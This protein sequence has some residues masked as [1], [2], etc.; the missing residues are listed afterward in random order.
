[1]FEHLIEGIQTT[2]TLANI[3]S[4][5]FGTL[6][7]I[8]VGILP[9][10]GPMVGMVVFLPFTFA[11]E[12]HL[13]LSLLLGVFCGGYFGGAVPAILMG[14]PGVPSSL[15]TSF[16]GFPLTQKGESQTALSAA[17]LGSFGGGI[18]SVLILIFL[19]PILAHVAA[20]FGP[21]EYFSVSCPCRTVYTLCL[22]VW[23]C[24]A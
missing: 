8:I 1:M 22:C 11:M 4:L 20:S 6:V 18:L 13:A 5:V 3:A 14:T 24:S 15:I 21:P 23:V 7:G 16:D 10:I 12:P 2:L 17:L 19:A 9:G